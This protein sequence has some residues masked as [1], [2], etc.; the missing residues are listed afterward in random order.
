MG[1]LV[2]NDIIPIF[3][4]KMNMLFGTRLQRYYLKSCESY[5]SARNS[6]YCFRDNNCRFA[7]KKISKEVYNDK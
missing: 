4:E 5:F 1:D 2:E 7:G 6:D 3:H